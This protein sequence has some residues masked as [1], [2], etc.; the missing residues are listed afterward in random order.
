MTG[1]RFHPWRRMR[2]LGPAWTLEWTEHLPWDVYGFTDWPSRTI[3]LREGMTF[4]ERRCTITHEVEHVLRGPASRCDV[5]A[6]EHR[7]N[8]HTARLLLPSVRAIADALIWHR[9]D[10]EG[11]AEEL[12]VDPWM[13]EVRLSTLLPA[14]EGRYLRRRL[15]EAEAV[16]HTDESLARL[17]EVHMLVATS[18]GDVGVAHDRDADRLRHA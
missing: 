8:V 4:E 18:D 9:G 12:W 6:E 11:A 10:Y 3:Y 15:A 2:E 1:T 14:L 5:L 7:V 13:L 16:G 17:G